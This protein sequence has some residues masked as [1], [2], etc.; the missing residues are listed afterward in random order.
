MKKVMYSV[1][2]IAIFSLSS[3][4]TNNASIESNNE[5]FDTVS[6]RWRTVYH[7]ANGNTSY[8]EWTYGNCNS[9]ESGLLTPIR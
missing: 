2:T 4:T 8:G 3:F 6:C 1:A 5:A 7:H 9:S